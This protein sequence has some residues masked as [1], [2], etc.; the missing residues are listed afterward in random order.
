M[1]GYM[2]MSQVQ[3]PTPLSPGQLHKVA[4]L[5][6]ALGEPTRLR[7]LQSICHGPRS[8]TEIVEHTEAT[9]ANVSKHLSL[10]VHAGV[11]ERRRDGQRVFYGMRD[12]LVPRLCELVC[13]SLV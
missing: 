13:A 8:V 5:F 2:A 10:L 3:P 11:L 12:Q 1:Y 4:S 6:K 9:Q 7:I